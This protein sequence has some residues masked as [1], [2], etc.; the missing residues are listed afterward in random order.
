MMLL[1]LAK[2]VS[3]KKTEGPPK[4]I[5][6]N[7][8]QAS[9]VDDDQ[10]T[11]SESY[12]SRASELSHAT[13]FDR[14]ALAVNHIQTM[15]TH[16][17]EETGINH[18]LANA[19]HHLITD[20][21]NENNPS[22]TTEYSYQATVDVK[23]SSDDH[24]ELTVEGLPDRM[25][26]ITA[27]K[28][29]QNICVYDDACIL[30]ELQ[31]TLSENPQ[32]QKRETNI[33]ATEFEANE[34]ESH[35]GTT[36]DREP[37][38]DIDERQAAS[39]AA[40]S[41]RQKVGQNFG[42]RAEKRKRELGEAYMGRHYDKQ[43]KKFIPVEK[44]KQV[45]GPRC[46]CK[47]SYL[48]CYK[49]T[50]ECRKNIH[51][52]VW[53]MTWGE[54]RIFVRHSVTSLEVKERTTDSSN[55]RRQASLI[56]N[57]QGTRVCKTMFMNTTSLKQWYILECLKQEPA[58]RQVEAEVVV[59]KASSEKVSF[60][61]DFLRKIPKMPSHY[62]RK[63][64]SKLYLE[65][66]FKTYA[67]LFK[68]YQKHC[69]LTGK[70]SFLS[71]TAFM[72]EVNSSKIS[73]FQPRK[74]MCDV[75][76]SYEK[77]NLHETEYYIH[78]RLK[79]AAQEEK[80]RDKADAADSDGPMVLCMDV[81]RVLLA[82]YLQASALYYKTKLQVHNFTVYNLHT[83][84]V[85][86]YV[87]NEMEGGM[88]ANEF[89]SCLIDFLNR[90]TFKKCIIYSDG[91]TYQNRNAILAT[92]LRH[93][94]TTNKKVVEQKFLEK[95]HTQIVSVFANWRMSKFATFQE[96]CLKIFRFLFGRNNAFF[97]SNLME[98]HLK[99]CFISK[100]MVMQLFLCYSFHFSRK[101]SFASMR[102]TKM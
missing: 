10:H 61:K 36:T 67:D 70:P 79:E 58:E 41:G 97:A 82:P 68:E 28:S 55:S 80:R 48:Q 31:P 24:S 29:G 44:K 23:P 22:I 74:D 56:Y 7:A 5:Q 101:C 94:C 13:N 75:C 25:T 72:T 96:S 47:A 54:K 18:P 53:S 16:D 40:S 19:T 50:D 33:N 43:A 6:D 51:K 85:R 63:D 99:C 35:R 59:E 98:L 100:F 77:G 62:C 93:F 9:T 8:Q 66:L 57:L 17:S 20:I 27:E 60:L 73:I 39:T 92:A 88:T 42:K 102:K 87:W 90:Q 14:Q 76:F 52:E 2:K 11:S 12:P 15:A 69:Q 37:E 3:A 89:A 32:L 86:C 78:R 64:T 95:G 65:P 1:R 91:C 45:L 71:R 30:T 84:D 4:M 38:R 49:L 83:R 34:D 46:T 81:Q 21:Q 26:K